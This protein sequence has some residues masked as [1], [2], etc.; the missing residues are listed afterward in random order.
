[1]LV[2]QLMWKNVDNQYVFSLTLT[3]QNNIYVFD[4]YTQ[5]ILPLITYHQL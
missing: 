3:K 5:N 1:M 2:K 4:Q